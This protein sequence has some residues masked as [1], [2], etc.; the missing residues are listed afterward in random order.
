MA[1]NGVLEQKAAYWRRSAERYKATS[2]KNGALPR[3]DWWRYEYC[4][5]PYLMLASDEYIAQRWLDQYHNNVS[6]TAAGQIA[7]RH[8]FA[9]DHG[10]F[11]PLFTHLTM[12]FGSRGGVPAKLASDGNQ[13]MGRYFAKGEPTGVRLFSGYPE[14]LDGVI[15]KFGQREHIERMLKDGE[16]RITPSTFYSQ[17]SLSKAMHDLESERQFHHPAFDAVRLGRTHAKTKTGFDGPIEDGF[18]KE[19]VRCPEYVLWCACRDIDRRM[20]DDFDADAALIIRKPDVFASRFGSGLRNVW[21]R[22]KIKVGPVTYYDPCSSVHRKERPAHLKHFQFAYQREWR[23]CAFPTAS[24]M[25]A[26]AFNI[27]I[28]S[29]EDIAEMVVLPA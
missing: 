23:L 17:A 22:V 5:S 24:Q 16:V 26:S 13:M 11:G 25:P 3:S 1:W 7:P 18:I 9:D 2:E 12:E 6:L 29:L 4:Q 8:D 14:N 20:P 28:S 27:Q 10:M 19:T 21:P 15:V